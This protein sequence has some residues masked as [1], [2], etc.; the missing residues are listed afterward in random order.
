[1]IRRDHSNRMVSQVFLWTYFN[2]EGDRV[3]ESDRFAGR[4]A[5]EEWMGAEWSELLSSGVDEVALVDED[6]DRILYRMGLG[7]E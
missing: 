1:V 6:R 7:A 5:A 4:E 3:G 2:A